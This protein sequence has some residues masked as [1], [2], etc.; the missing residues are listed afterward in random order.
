M[1]ALLDR[2]VNV[3]LEMIDNVPHRE[4]LARKRRCMAMLDHLQGYYGMASLE[5]LSQGLAVIAGLDDW[6]AGRIRE[7]AGLAE[8]APLP[9]VLTDVAGL[10]QTIEALALDLDRTAELGRASRRFM[11]QRWSDA[12]VAA[13]LAETYES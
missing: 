6:N 2:G 9:W 13:R 12:K 3:E 4:C 1:A 8:D 5:G 10:A 11:E 7:F